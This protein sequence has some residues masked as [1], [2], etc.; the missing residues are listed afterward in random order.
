MHLGPVVKGKVAKVGGVP[1]KKRIGPLHGQVACCL[2][3]LRHLT[4]LIDGQQVVLYEHLWNG[5]VRKNMVV[6][7]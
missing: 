2:Q 7:D 6:F 1:L 3:R 5:N 4:Q